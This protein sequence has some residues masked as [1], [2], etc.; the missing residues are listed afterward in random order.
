[1]DKSKDVIYLFY[2]QDLRQTFNFPT[3]YHVL[4]GHT[5]ELSGNDHCS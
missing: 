1:M 4:Q 5:L 2:S 3:I